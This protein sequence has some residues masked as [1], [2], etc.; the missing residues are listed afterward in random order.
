MKRRI[1]GLDLNGRVDWAARDW[2]VDDAGRA[3]NSTTVIQGGLVSSVI[4]TVNGNLVAGPQAEKAPHGRGIGWGEIGDPKSRNELSSSLDGITQ[5]SSHA[6]SISAAVDALARHSDDVVLAVPDLSD[7]AEASQ[8]ALLAAVVNRRRRGRLLWRSVAA[9]LG[10]LDEVHIKADQIGKRFCILTHTGAGLEVQVLTLRIDRDHPEH[11]APQRDG[12]GHL[13]VQEI[14]L[15]A[16]FASADLVTREKNG[17]VDWARCEP[18]RLG[19]R[20][21]TGVGQPGDVEVLRTFNANWVT[22]T[23]PDITIDALFPQALVIPRLETGVTATFLV[24]PLEPRFAARLVRILQPAL[25]PIVCVGPDVIA[26]GCLSAGRLIERGLPHYFDRL[27]P[28]AIAVIRGEDPVF[29]YLIP[30][31]AVVPANKEYASDDLLGFEWGQ[32]KTDAEFYILKGNEE[33]RHWDVHKM[34]GPRT[35]VP[36]I[37][38][39]RQTPGQSWAR[40]TVSSTEWD[41][42]ARNPVALEWEKLRPLDQTPEQILEQLRS[43]PP[44]IP[45]RIVERPHLAIWRGSD[46]TGAGQ[47]ARYAKQHFLLPHAKVDAAHWSKEIRAPRRHPESKERFW[48]IGTDGELPDGLSSEVVE[49]FKTA[50]AQ[51]SHTV[52]SATL[53]HPLPNNDLLIALTWCFAKCPEDVQDAILS[54]LQADAAGLSHALTVPKRSLTVLRQGAG[55]AIIGVNRLT[56]LFNYLQICDLN[57]D[58]INALAMAL[59]RREEA[60]MALTR[61]HV[62]AFTHRLGDELLEQ[63]RSGSFKLKFRNTLSALA[64]L[65]RW[66]VRE[67]YAL[68]ASRD[69]VANEL[70]ITLLHAK[71]LMSKTKQN[72][73]QFNVKNQQID[74]IVEYLDGAGDPDILRIIENDDEGDDAS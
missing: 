18:S 59:T 41:E 17:H 42:L 8:G 27:E 1:V 9:F 12:P 15:D 19:S 60:P 56:V 22:V 31:N 24:T 74:A 67:P 51:M 29:E 63:I 43:P 23:A 5:G 7:F 55:R 40:L 2:D 45:I 64:G 38:R 48:A 39:I 16:L 11:V 35:N 68:L 44:T 66:R 69:P 33:V 14:G 71:E 32:G 46:W 25:G 73:Q 53:K 6:G 10:L 50:L 20:I 61:D 58:T 36:V 37:I 57:N 65:F 54:A 13:H 49:G 34:Y 52:M 28:I 3:A 21:V 70:K 26:R 47:L 30:S 4:R 62:D 72:I